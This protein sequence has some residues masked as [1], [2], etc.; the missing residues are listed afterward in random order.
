MTFSIPVKMVSAPSVGG[1][2]GFRKSWRWTTTTPQVTFEGYYA[3]PAIRSLGIYEMTQALWT[4]QVHTCAS[5][6]L[7][8]SS[9]R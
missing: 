2:E 1:L 5:L 8:Q 7:T 3:R 4:V 9:G 6:L